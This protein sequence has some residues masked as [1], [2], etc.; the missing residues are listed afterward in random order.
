M[1]KIFL[2]GQEL[3]YDELTQAPLLPLH[4]EKSGGAWMEEPEKDKSGGGG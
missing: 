1:E 2:N 4:D 3:M